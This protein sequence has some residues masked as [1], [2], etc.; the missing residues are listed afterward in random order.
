MKKLYLVRR[1]G[2]MLRCWNVSACEIWKI[3]SCSKYG[4]LMLR[5]WNVK[6]EETRE[7]EKSEEMT[8]HTEGSW[9][10]LANIL[11]YFASELGERDPTMTGTM[12]KLPRAG[13]ITCTDLG[14]VGSQDWSENLSNVGQLHLYTVLVLVSLNAHHLK[15]PCKKGKLLVGPWV[16]GHLPPPVSR[17]SWLI[18]LLMVRSP[19]GV[20]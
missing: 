1:W 13:C 19:R 6:Y 16:P 7:S 2:L 9:R 11:P 18:C 5:C 17:S 10:Y 8:K 3:V 12:V 20:W 4:G 14:S 15:L